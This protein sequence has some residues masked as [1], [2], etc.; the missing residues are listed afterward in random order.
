[1]SGLVVL[2]VVLAGLFAYAAVGKLADV[3]A[4]R[5]ASLDLGVP[6]GIASVSVVGVPLVELA[7]AVGLL[8]GGSARLS[9]AAGAALTVAF[10]ALIASNLRRGNRPACNCFGAGNETPIGPK[11]LARNAVM[12]GGFAVIALT[13]DRT[14]AG[15]ALAEVVLARWSP[16]SSLAMFSAVGAFEALLIVFLLVR[17]RRT[18]IEDVDQPEVGLPIGSHAPSFVLRDLEGNEWSSS[19]LFQDKPTLLTFVDPDC[20]PCQA[21]LPE[22]ADWQ[23]SYPQD[24]A[25]ALVSRGTASVNRTKLAGHALDLVLLQEDDEVAS[26][27][28]TPATPSAVLVT[29]LG[30]VRGS[31]AGAHAIRH[32]VEEAVSVASSTLIE[33]PQLGTDAPLFSLPEMSGA[34][35]LALLERRGRLTL[36]VFWSPTCEFCRALARDL[37][38]WEAQLDQEFGPRLVVISD[39]S[40]T[41]SDTPFRDVALDSGRLLRRAY[42]VTGTPT[43]VLV[44]AEGRVASETAR[45]SE[46]VMALAR[47]AESVARVGRRLSDKARDLRVGTEP[48]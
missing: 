17:R 38:G 20:S 4:F 31:A 18:T 16:E 36:V 12:I 35:E 23:A 29:A 34:G 22:L 48:T 27:Y 39:G 6:N 8:L 19:T 41:A 46:Q 30:H 9:A 40:P 10:T 25:I 7:I 33:G 11:S 21:L 47:R 2:R 28:G 43:A 44:D 5:R 1:M 42:G 32:L 26:A 13:D 15:E 45:G 37:S 3:D 24:L 14:G